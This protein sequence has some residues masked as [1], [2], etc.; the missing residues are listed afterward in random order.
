MSLKA[1]NS[2]LFWNVLHYIDIPGKNGGVGGITPP[3]SEVGS[4]EILARNLENT[5]GGTKR[6]TRLSSVSPQK[7]KRPKR[8]LIDT[9]LLK[10]KAS[11]KEGEE[12]DDEEEEEFEV[13]S[14]V[15]LKKSQVSAPTGKLRNVLYML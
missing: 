14:I 7:S 1:Q 6:K 9:Y 10:E 5:Q 15:D 11:K 2:F 12:E 8:N 13:Q 3:A 4:E